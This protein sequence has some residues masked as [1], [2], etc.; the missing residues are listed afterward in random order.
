MEAEYIQG[1][2][3]IVLEKVIIPY[4]VKDSEDT[5][6]LRYIEFR[7]DP[8]TG[9]Y[10]RVQPFKKKYN[11]NKSKYLFINN[12]TKPENCPFCKSNLKSFLRYSVDDRF[13]FDRKTLGRSLIFV[14]EQLY[15]KY[16]AIVIPNT[17]KHIESIENLSIYDFFNT[18]NLI[19][20]FV[21][22]NYSKDK[23]AKY[24]YV[25]L[26]HTLF[27]GASERHIHFQVEQN[28]I[29]TNYHKIVLERSQEY[30]RQN[31][32][33]LLEDYIATEVEIGDRDIFSG[34]FIDWVANFSPYGDYDVIGFVKSF[35][36][37]TM[38][39]INF[40]QF[41][42]ELF[43]FILKYI[44]TTKNIAFNLS[45]IDTSYIKEP[46]IYPM[47]RILS[48]IPNKSGMTS[49]GY[50]DVIHLESLSRTLPEECAQIIRKAYE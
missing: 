37:F 21:N 29:P 12:S 44:E 50:S 46:G 45:I 22:V 8:L 4:H 19:R 7:K 31:R 47:I 17:E 15:A 25:N 3:G 32:T 11:I 34:K 20:D 6:H 35:G 5:L 2:N 13:K 1:K 30:F 43:E 48:R 27:A 26:N 49:L 42:E 10:T 16:H 18:F 28:F 41:L 24:V 14:A 39:E 33:S 23:T 9:L 40:K 36:I 38:S